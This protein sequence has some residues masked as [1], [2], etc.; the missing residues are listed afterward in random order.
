LPERKRAAGAPRR[1]KR[2]ERG[3]EAPQVDARGSAREQNDE[4]ES[5]RRPRGMWSGT[6][7]FGLVTIPVELFPATRAARQSLRMLAPD[8]TP[9]A[10]RYFSSS[11]KALAPEELERGYKLDDGSFVVIDD[12][13]LERLLPEQSR[14]I[15]LTR[16]VPRASIPA[17]YFE[18]TYIMAPAGG[19]SAAYRLLAATMQ[20]LDKVGI[21]TFVMRE[22]QYLVAISARDGL[23]AA[24]TMHFADELRSPEELGLPAPHDVDARRVAPLR[25]AIKQLGKGHVAARELADSYWQRLEKLVAE[26]RAHNRDVVPA[27]GGAAN[28][29][30]VAEVID[31]MAVL[32]KSLAQQGQTPE[33]SHTTKAKRPG[34]RKG[35]NGKGTRKS[36]AAK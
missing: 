30:N 25:A 28:D 22:R 17:R 23:L 11:G 26:K 15:D 20:R 33:E 29:Q 16:F 7:S 27:A 24:H 9:L 36:Q 13:E 3:P 19:S 1:R 8:G 32:R 4:D 18:R 10:R 6:L 2:P 34:L 14:D 21:A 35:G 31:L 5:P 12:E